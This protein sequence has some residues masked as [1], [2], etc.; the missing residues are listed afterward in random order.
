MSL[1]NGGSMVKNGPENAVAR[2][3]SDEEQPCP[4]G[5]RFPATLP[6]SLA[7]V[8]AGLG[9]ARAAEPTRAE[10]RIGINGLKLG[11][12][13]G[14]TETMRQMDYGDAIG[15]ELQNLYDDVVAQPVPDRFLNLLNQLEKNMLS[16]GL[17]IGAPGERE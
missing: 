1:Q 15:K 11:K 2:V 13:K 9:A 10:Q 6:R 5:R 7:A 4:D 14:N 17:S 8:A 3:H 12:P 16:S